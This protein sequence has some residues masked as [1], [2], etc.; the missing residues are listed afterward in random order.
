MWLVSD[1]LLHM[2]ERAGYVVWFFRFDLL[3]SKE[4]L[5]FSIIVSSKARSPCVIMIKFHPI[6]DVFSSFLI[7][8]LFDRLQQLRYVERFQNISIGTLVN[9]L[10]GIF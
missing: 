8:M 10:H 6:A 4:R 7:Q 9:R 3:L 5:P 2:V 1:I